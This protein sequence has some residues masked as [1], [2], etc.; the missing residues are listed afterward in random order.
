MTPGMFKEIFPGTRGT[1][2]LS[3]S[4]ISNLGQGTCPPTI[5]GDKIETFPSILDL[6]TKD[7]YNVYNILN[8]LW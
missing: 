7:A 6:V 4:R 3:H 8:R 5:W 2:S 1:G